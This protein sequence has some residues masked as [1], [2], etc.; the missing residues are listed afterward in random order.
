M[1]AYVILVFKKLRQE[2]SKLKVS[3]CYIYI[4]MSGNIVIIMMMR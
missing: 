2:H 3:L 4:V 1:V